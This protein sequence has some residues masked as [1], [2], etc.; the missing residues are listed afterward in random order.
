MN[1]INL[2][3]ILSR[4]DVANE[5]FHPFD[6]SVVTNDKYELRPGA[7]DQVPSS[8]GLRIIPEPRGRIGENA[9]QSINDSNR[10]DLDRLITSIQKI[11]RHPE[12][13][14]VILSPS[15]SVVSDA[16][17]NGSKRICF[18]LINNKD[19]YHDEFK[20]AAACHNN[21]KR[22]VER[23]GFKISSEIPFE[24]SGGFEGLRT[25]ASGIRYTKKPNL[26]WWALLLPLLLLLLYL[27]FQACNFAQNTLSEAFRAGLETDA[28]IIVLD[29]SSSM[30]HCFEKVRQQ[31]TDLI[32]QQRKKWFSNSYIDLIVFDGYPNSTFDELKKLDDDT[33]KTVIN[34]IPTKAGG[35][36]A[37]VPALK[38]AVEEIDKHNEQTTIILITDG[39]DN[40]MQNLIDHPE[41]LKDLISG[42]KSADKLLIINTVAVQ[43][44]NE[45]KNTQNSYHNILK[46]LSQK[47]NG[48]HEVWDFS[49]NP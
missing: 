48:V 46:K 30:E 38:K 40:N 27:M 20:A 37:I 43:K 34:Q 31:T 15:V 39:E 29:K 44:T 10:I 35:S 24:E 23:S 12:F 28:V 1:F 49:T 32:T 42:K 4:P 22:A 13:D 36:T 41:Q 3:Q 17:R 18:G 14:S 8:D 45:S 33:V 5:F 9:M 21:F 7:S 26:L 19:L 11:R 16:A 6:S 2:R 47:F 25:W